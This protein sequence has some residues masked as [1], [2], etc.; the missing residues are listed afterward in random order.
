MRV[1]VIVSM[2][3]VADFST[4]VPAPVELHFHLRP[5]GTLKEKVENALEG[6]KTNGEMI[7]DGKE[8]IKLLGEAMDE[9][10]VKQVAEKVFSNLARVANSGD[11][12]DYFDL[13]VALIGLLN[14]PTVKQLV[15]DPIVKQI[16]GLLNPIVKQIP[17]LLDPIV[18]QIPG[19]LTGEGEKTDGGMIEDGKEDL[20]LQGAGEAVDGEKVKQVPDLTGPEVPAGPITAPRPEVPAGPSAGP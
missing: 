4:A 9:E 1:V 15:V 10:K 20:K 11:G 13:G 6:E 17:G 19:L 3:I 16:P 12:Q 5:E 7:E 2:M 8:D 14:N 18:K